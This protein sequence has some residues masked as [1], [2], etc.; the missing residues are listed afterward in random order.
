[1]PTL[2]TNEEIINLININSKELESI[3]LASEEINIRVDELGKQN[4]K[5]VDLMNAEYGYGNWQDV[6]AKELTFIPRE[7]FMDKWYIIKNPALRE[8]IEIDDIKITTQE[9]DNEKESGI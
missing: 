2:I 1:M 9:I 8:V 4:Q 3:N 5:F 6:N 7:E